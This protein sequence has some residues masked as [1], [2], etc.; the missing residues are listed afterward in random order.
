MMERPESW[1]QWV[2]LHLSWSAPLRAASLQPQ[3]SA[4]A[5]QHWAHSELQVWVPG[6]SLCVEWC[7]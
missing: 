7:A 2:S 1:P 6:R 3:L 5:L 4:P